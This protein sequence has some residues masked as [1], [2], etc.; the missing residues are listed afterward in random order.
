M[1]KTFHSTKKPGLFTYMPPSSIVPA[2]II[3]H[4]RF[5][6]ANANDWM[7]YVLNGVFAILR[8]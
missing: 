5:P 7:T 4:Y 6:A 8:N 2:D 3:V 1:E